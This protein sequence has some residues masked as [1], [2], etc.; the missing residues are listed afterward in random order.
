MHGGGLYI[1]TGGLTVAAA[2]SPRTLLYG[3]VTVQSGGLRVTGV[4][5]RVGGEKG[6]G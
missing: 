3:G 5:G 2:D 1:A 6:R 4:G